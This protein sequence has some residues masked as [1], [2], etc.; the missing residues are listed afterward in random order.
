MFL[1]CVPI[2]WLEFSLTT[3]QIWKTSLQIFQEI[4][5]SSKKIRKFPSTSHKFPNVLPVKV[6]HSAIG[7]LFLLGND[8]E[9]LTGS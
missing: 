9:I 6:R 1:F 2:V 8:K 5:K 7:K 3:L 4:W